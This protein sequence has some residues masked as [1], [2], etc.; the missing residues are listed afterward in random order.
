MKQLI[1]ILLFIFAIG[2]ASLGS[3]SW[4]H[5]SPVAEV[6]RGGNITISQNPSAS[7]L[8]ATKKAVDFP[9]I[10]QSRLWKHLE[11]LAGERDRESDR[12]FTRNYISEQLKIVGF[13]PQLQPFERGTNIFAEEKVQTQQ[14]VQFSSPPTT[15]LYSNHPVLMIMLPELQ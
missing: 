13:S 10:D 1:W 15:I 11:T 7:P 6:G 5:L 3:Y 8:P 12:S 4:Q 2:A 14:R 9:Q